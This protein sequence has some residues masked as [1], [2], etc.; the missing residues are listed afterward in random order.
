M[1]ASEDPRVELLTPYVANFHSHRLPVSAASHATQS[2]RRRMARHVLEALD[3]QRAAVEPAAANALA[4]WDARE[5]LADRLAASVRDATVVVGDD[6][7]LNA[8]DAL[9]SSMEQLRGSLGG[10]Q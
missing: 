10:A 9:A 5:A 1:A 2:G 6:E 8:E 4:A 7:W 3:D